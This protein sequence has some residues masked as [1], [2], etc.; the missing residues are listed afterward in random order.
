MAIGLCWRAI[1][2]ERPC[3]VSS[4]FVLMLSIAS[5]SSALSDA[6]EVVSELFREVVLLGVAGPM[7]LVS[8][9]MITTCRSGARSSRAPGMT[10]AC[11][12]TSTPCDDTPC[13]LRRVRGAVRRARAERTRQLLL[14]RAVHATPSRRAVPSSDV[15]QGQHELIQRDQ[16]LR[17]ARAKREATSTSTSRARSTPDTGMIIESWAIG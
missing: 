16:E 9:T 10:C 14:L 2:R 7:T 1:S 13:G 5:S 6:I 17:A 4:W 15:M 12:A 11:E 3:V 8:L